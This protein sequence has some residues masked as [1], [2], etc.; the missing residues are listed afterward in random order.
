MSEQEHNNA[1]E[2]ALLRKDFETLQ[3]DMSE[4]KRDIKKLSTAW[5]T[6]ENLVAFI[7]WL[8]GLAAA[9]ALIT[10]MVKGWFSMSAPKE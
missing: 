9:I 7:K 2:L 8:A 3:A 5:S 4:I 10:G 1:L 6:A